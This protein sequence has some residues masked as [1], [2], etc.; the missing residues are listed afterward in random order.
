VSD[1]DDARRPLGTGRKPPED[2]AGERLDAPS[3]GASRLP[4][5]A[6]VAVL[7]AGLLVT[8]TLT[9]V[10]S[11]VH[12]NNEKRLLRQRAA[13]VA[14]VLGAAIPNVQAPLLS[15]GAVADATDANRSDVESVLAPLLASRRIV[16]ASVWPSRAPDP[17]PIQVFGTPPELSTLGSAARRGMVSRAMMGSPTMAIV[18]LLDRADRRIGYAYSAGRDARYVVYAEAPL[19]PNRRARVDTNAAF[20]GIDYAIYLGRDASIPRLIAAS[21]ANP[22]FG[23][24]VASSTVAFGDNTLHVV[25]TPHGELGGTLLPRLP[26]LIAVIGTIVSIAAALMTERLVRRRTDAER[27]ALENAQLF[28]EQRGVS[29]T[30]QH[31]LLPDRLPEID[32]LDVSVRY[33]P[34]ADG[35]DIGG[36]W[37]DVVVIDDQRVLFV[38]G[39]VSGRGLKAATVMA[40]LRY[41]IRAY[42]AQGDEPAAIL[43]KLSKLVSVERDG[44]FATVLCGLV[45]VAAHRVTTAN[46]GHPNPLVV[47]GREAD[48]LATTVGPPIGVDGGTYASTDATVPAGATLVGYT[49]GLYERRREHPDVG[50]GRLRDASLGFDSLDALLDGLLDKMAPDGAQDDTAI[51]GLQ[52]RT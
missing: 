48:F 10:T 18:D 31:S 4:H 9:V 22:D 46:A 34:G 40:S 52:W 27:L 26:W 30:L 15:A 3:S 51:L 8:A 1:T 25:L 43:S 44:H 7:V 19:P 2:A 24:L 37:Y 42:A 14:A 29:Q 49:D 17:M 47:T 11:V 39:D 45:D 33:A 36:D 20:A 32:G 23:G 28:R 6:S 5:I 12:N 35:V 21:V 41:A 13:E 16:S 50:L 38:V